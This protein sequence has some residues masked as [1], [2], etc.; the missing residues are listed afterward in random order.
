MAFLF[1]ALGSRNFRYYWIAMFLSLIGS[2]IQILALG[3]LT[4]ELT[5]SA[6][7][8]GLIG[9]LSTIPILI[10]SLPSGVITDRYNKRRLLILTQA[11]M[12]LMAFWLYYLVK[13]QATTITDI[14]IFSFLS[15]LVM[16]LD[17]PLRQAFVS[18]IVEPHQLANAIPLNSVAFNGA[19]IIGPALAGFLIS[20]AGLASCFFINAFSFIFII[21][22]LLLMASSHKHQ[23]AP[24]L[25]GLR[26][27]IV[28]VNR[29][30]LY[31]RDVSVYIMMIV[32]QSFFLAPIMQ[33]MPLFA[34]NVFRVGAA[35]LGWLMSAAGLGALAGAI[36]VAAWPL[37]HKKKYI[38]FSYLLA[39]AGLT[40]FAVIQNFVW[41]C[42]AMFFLMLGFVGTLSLV[43]VA[44]QQDVPHRLRGRLMSV[45]MLAF[46]GLTPFGNLLAG[47]LADW[48]GLGP[49]FFFFGILTALF[50][51][52]GLAGV[53]KRRPQKNRPLPK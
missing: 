37:A 27:G 23:P 26:R 45:Y 28:E 42:W 22:V 29:Y 15:G 49:T 6:V 41:A 30:I 5:N 43:N 48:T 9:F 24:P 36:W 35:G 1:S 14:M 25:G 19:R 20:W 21:L 39:A 2:W 50:A 32:V 11:V 10:F 3:W 47:Y 4:I 51:L 7:Y 13:N 16:A 46:A 38:Y 52:L 31:H 44:L 40:C 33:F 53:K 12:M 18:E 8:L 34:Q 17:G